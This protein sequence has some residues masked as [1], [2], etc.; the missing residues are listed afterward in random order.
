MPSCERTASICQYT[1]KDE[2]DWVNACDPPLEWALVKDKRHCI[3]FDGVHPFMGFLTPMTSENTQASEIAAGDAEKYGGIYN[4]LVLPALHKLRRLKSINAQQKCREKEK[5]RNKEVERWSC[6]SA[7]PF[8][9]S[10]VHPTHPGDE[11]YRTA[12][13]YRI[14]RTITESALEEEI[15]RFTQQEPE[16][17]Q[18][19]TIVRDRLSGRPSGYCFV[20]FSKRVHMI[21]SIKILRQMRLNGRQIG[22]DVRRGG[23]ETCPDEAS[24]GNISFRKIPQKLMRPEE[25]EYADKHPSRRR[26]WPTPP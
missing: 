13:L 1:Q 7:N 20:V 12:F 23:V 10:A 25:R 17:I 5:N 8:M 21:E 16:K 15:L 18:K 9:R 3:R 4:A 19:V 2:H 6:A 26:P 22:V 14:P 11:A 24:P